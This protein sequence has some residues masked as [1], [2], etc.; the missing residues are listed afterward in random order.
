MATP[1]E[2]EATM[3]ARLPEQTG[4]SLDDW[5]KELHGHGL[6]AHG[7][8][9][10][11]LKRDHGVSHGYANLIAHKY[12]KSDAGS[13]GSSDDLVAA[14]YAGAKAAVRPVY[15]AI[16]REVRRFG[17]DVELAPKK[18]YVSLRRSK[19]F[20]LLQPAA[21]R[22]DVGLALKGEPAAGRLEAAGSWNAMVSHRVRVTGVD[23]VDAELIGWLRRAYERA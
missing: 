15:D 19:Q 17:T 12:R 7:Q 11:M 3:I 20:A 6:S 10:A 13:S 14:Q 18:Q 5:K 22:L 4:R 1:D 2:Q 21:A 9:V 8:I 16:L 23:D